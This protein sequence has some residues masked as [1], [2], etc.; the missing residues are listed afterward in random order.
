M[1]NKESTKTKQ[2][3]KPYLRPDYKPRNW[4]QRNWIELV[5][6]AVGV[7]IIHIFLLFKAFNG[8]ELNSTNASE[9]GSFIGGYMGTLFALV[10]V[11]FLYTTL[12]DQRRT[13]EIE[14]FET[15]FFELIRLH[16]DNVQE[17]TLKTQNGKK[18][19][20]LFIREFREIM[21]IVKDV[22]KNDK[23]EKKQIIEI[24]YLAFFYGIGPNSTRILKNSLSNYD[25]TKVKK[26]TDELQSQKQKVKK[27]R[28]FNYVPFEGH[29][30]RLGHYYRHLFQS[31]AYCHNKKID[32]DKYEYIKLIRAQLSNHEQAL[33]FLNS[34]SKLGKP[35][36]DENLIKTYRLIKNIP[37]DFFD[38]K[39]EIDIK[40][41]YP[42]MIFE[43]EEN[44]VA[45]NV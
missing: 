34:I 32:I 39:K 23:L 15:R 5:T 45:N 20:V 42:E 9:F 24:S 25:K 8:N 22:F 37:E 26:L 36:K 31:I 35:W 4:W 6:I 27:E 40:E 19:F 18:I 3:V 14:K 2:P 1:E 12:R 44:T 7:I 16:R 28:K 43:Y 10:S 21:K 33:L 38:P 29:Q 13:S 41:L 30:S 17:I 11:I